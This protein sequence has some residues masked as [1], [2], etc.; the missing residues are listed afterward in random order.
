ME[1]LQRRITSDYDYTKAFSNNIQRS[2]IDIGVS[3]GY[4]QNAHWDTPKKEIKTFIKNDLTRMDKKY[5]IIVPNVLRPLYWAIG[6]FKKLDKDFIKSKIQIATDD[7]NDSSKHASIQGI[8]EV[9]L[10]FERFS[11]AR[12]SAL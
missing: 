2:V 7:L 11:N 1:I 5:S 6:Y 10:A 8:H 12:Q 9:S 4:I 3:Q